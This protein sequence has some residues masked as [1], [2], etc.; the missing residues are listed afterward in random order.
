M[1][2]MDDQRYSIHMHYSPTAW[3]SVG[4]RL[5]RWR[6]FDTNLH[7]AQINHLVKRWNKFDSQANFYVKGGLGISDGPHGANAELGGFFGLAT[8]WEDRRYFVSYNNRYTQLN[9]DI[10]FFQQSARVG[11]APYEGD[12]GDLHTWLMLQIDHMPENE[13]QIV[14]TPLVRFFKG[15][16]MT[17]FGVSS[18]GDLLFNYIYRF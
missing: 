16:F 15:V 9:D 17:E 8:D 12:F 7:S 18:K 11:W 14:A 6:A 2:I 10:G 5:E 4:Y 3:T 13:D 1:M